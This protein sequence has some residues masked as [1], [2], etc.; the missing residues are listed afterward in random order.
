[1]QIPYRTH[2]SSPSSLSWTQFECNTAFLPTNPTYI[3][4]KIQCNILF[5]RHNKGADKLMHIYLSYMD[6]LISS[7]H[8]PILFHCLIQKNKDQSIIFC[9]IL[10]RGYIDVEKHTHTHTSKCQNARC[11]LRQN[12][13]MIPKRPP[14]PKK[15]AVKKCNR[16]ACCTICK[17]RI[18]KALG[19]PIE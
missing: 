2:G 19:P 7:K 5:K 14:P 4:H 17:S 11:R 6:E 18:S 10:C 9:F 1:M 15:I 16:C 3:L 8:L 13:H 12:P